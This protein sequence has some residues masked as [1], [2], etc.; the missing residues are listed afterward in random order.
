MYIDRKKSQWEWQ[1]KTVALT[2]PLSACASGSPDGSSH[3][4]VNPSGST[5][6]H[7]HCSPSIPPFVLSYTSEDQLLSILSMTAG[8]MAE[9]RDGG[10]E[11]KLHRWPYVYFSVC[12]GVQKKRRTA[13][14]TES[15]RKEKGCPISFDV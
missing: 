15:Q 7:Y 9:R 8:E 11:P 14:R 1:I 10:V 13:L 5:P 6:L 3:P 4:L 2:A 12:V